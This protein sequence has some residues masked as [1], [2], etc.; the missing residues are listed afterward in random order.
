MR[1][2]R[3]RHAE[4]TALERQSPATA[5]PDSPI[6][7]ATTGSTPT[8]ALVRTSA[9]THTVNTDQHRIPLTATASDS[10][11]YTM[12]IPGD[13]GVV[14]PG[15][16]LLFAMTTDGTPASRGSFASPVGDAESVGPREA[17]CVQR[18]GASLARRS[19]VTTTHRPPKRK[20]RSPAGPMGVRAMSRGTSIAALNHRNQRGKSP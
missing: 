17:T 4:C 20:P 16:Y 8:F 14:L 2:S 12:Q 18:A 3:L 5:G 10:A 13:P 6:T 15:Y 1:G 9:V 11:G 19:E 7:V